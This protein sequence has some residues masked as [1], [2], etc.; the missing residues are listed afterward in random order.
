MGEHLA[1]KAKWQRVFFNRLFFSARGAY[2]WIGILVP[3][4]AGG[5][6]WLIYEYDAPLV[7]HYIQSIIKSNHPAR[8]LDS[9]T[10]PTLVEHLH[11]LSMIFIAASSNL[12]LFPT[13]ET[14]LIPCSVSEEK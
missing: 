1:T 9:E 8:V 12:S 14:N 13:I 4:L 7:N 11:Q 6:L 2:V 10:F 5:A 3:Y